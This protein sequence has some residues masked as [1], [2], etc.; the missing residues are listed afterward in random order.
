MKRILLLLLISLLLCGCQNQAAAPTQDTAPPPA[1][2]QEDPMVGLYDPNDKT[3]KQTNG[4]VKAY[5]LGDGEYAGLLSVGQQILVVSAD[6][7]ATILSGDAGHIIVTAAVDLSADYAPMQLCTDGST[8]AYYDKQHNQAVMLDT[9]LQE[10]SRISLPEGI[11]GNPAIVLQQQE[12]FYCLD[13]EIRAL[14]I[15]TGI[16][17]LVRSHL[18]ISQE[19][20]GHYFNGI[21]LACRVTD[22]HGQEKTQYLYSQTGQVIHTDLTMGYLITLN[23]DYF[24]VRTDGTTQQVLFGTAD[25]ETMCLNIQP[26]NVI[27]ALSLGGAVQ[28]LENGSN[29]QLDFYDFAS[30]NRSA[31]VTIENAQ[32]LKA[33]CSDNHYLWLLC[34]KTL[35]RWDPSRSL[36]EDETDYTDNLYTA[37]NPDTEGLTRCVQRSD[38]IAARHN[39]SIR[40]WQAAT[41]HD[42]SV[43]PEYQVSVI[44]AA[45]DRLEAV[46]EQL[47]EGFMSTTGKVQVNLV[48]QLNGDQPAVQFRDG[49]DLV[50]VIPCQ[51]IEQYFL[52]GLGFAVDTRVLGN[53]R[54]YDFWDELNPTGFAYTYDYATNALRADAEEFLYGFVDEV[55]MSFPT[56]DR[57][58]VFAAAVL[59]GN[60][61]VFSQPILQNKLTILCEAIREAYGLDSSPEVL[62]WEQYLVSHWA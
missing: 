58:R 42:Y 53:S 30:G 20:I 7:N 56:E 23:Q 15:Q 21:I 5:P 60:E 9:K 12:I 11:S 32:P 1:S 8:I 25:G 34:G 2:E 33:V 51:N 40:I 14:N 13:N 28:Y 29:L 43:V 46:L 49:A 38:R 50:M 61:Q 16:S 39:L 54:E 52:W 62:P 18:G 4:A 37:E 19:L 55:A 31:H 47:P 45:L 17:R 35:Y 24:A 27:S 22:E 10:L 59:P 48:R 57:A 3:E 36:T 6:G 26:E 41:D 44:N